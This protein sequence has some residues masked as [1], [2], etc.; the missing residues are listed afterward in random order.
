MARSFGRAKPEEWW[1]EKRRWSSLS[2]ESD[3]MGVQDS[4][5][6]HEGASFRYSEDRVTF[7]RRC[8][9]GDCKDRGRTNLGC[10]WHTRAA[11]AAMVL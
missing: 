5:L 2:P 3:M 6:P 10:K 11:A 4:P 7:Q 1:C 9:S 8:I